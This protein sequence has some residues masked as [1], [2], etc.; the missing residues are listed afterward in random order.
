MEQ[1]ETKINKWQ[2]NI[3]KQTSEY[4]HSNRE[5]NKKDKQHGINKH[6]LE[7]IKTNWIGQQ[8]R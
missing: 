6:K 3:N 2:A 8:T 1:T 7:Q 4:K 5:T